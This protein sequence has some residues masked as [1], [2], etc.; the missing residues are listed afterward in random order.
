MF[1][2]HPALGLLRKAIVS[3]AVTYFGSQH[4]EARI[5]A[6]GYNQYGEVLQHLNTTLA[7]PERQTTNETILTALTCMLLEIF[8]PTDPANFLK[9]QR[10]IEAIMRLRGPPTQST[11]ETATIFRGLRI[12]SIVSAL[13]ESRPSLYASTEWKDAPPAVTSRIGLLQHEVFTIL[14]D[15]SQIMSDCSVFN[16]AEINPNDRKS[17]LVR[18]TSAMSN[19]STLR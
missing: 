19:L 4:R 17:L 11:G 15:C 18:I 13:V 14:A 6:K 7:V 2:T 5:T 1:T 9:H 8:L 10:G 16:V 12:L 3:L